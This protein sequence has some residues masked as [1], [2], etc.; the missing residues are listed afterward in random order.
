MKNSSPN[1][2]GCGSIRLLLSILPIALTLFS[3]SASGSTYYVSVYGSDFNSGDASAPFRRLSKAA[4][5][6]RQPGDTVIVMDGTYDNEFVTAPG[7]VVD[8]AYSGAP[9]DPITFKAQNRGRAI[10]DAGNTTTGTSCN[11]AAAYFNLHSTAY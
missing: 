10:L 3:Q 2:A 9:G 1:L 4:S 11:G 6:A 5:A 7:Y 8:L